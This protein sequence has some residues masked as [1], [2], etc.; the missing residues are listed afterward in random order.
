MMFRMSVHGGVPHGVLQEA[1][2]DPENLIITE[3]VRHADL[4]RLVDWLGRTHILNWTRAWGLPQRLVIRGCANWGRGETL[5]SLL[6]AQICDR[7][8]PTSLLTTCGAN[9]AKEPIVMCRRS[10]AFRH[11]LREREGRPHAAQQSGGDRS[12]RRSGK[13]QLT[14]AAP[15]RP[16]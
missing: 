8:D 13:Q 2:D 16:S 11:P 5:I 9:H 1:A 12:D 14:V 15:L 10:A 6:Q 4:N 3:A 7:T